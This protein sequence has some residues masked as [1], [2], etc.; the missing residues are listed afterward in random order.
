MAEKWKLSWSMP[1]G[2]P[3]LEILERTGQYVFHGSPAVIEVFE[4]R[5]ATQF[6]NKT[7]KNLPT[8]NRLFLH[9]ISHY[10]LYL[11]D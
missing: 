3:V 7:G 10:P 2:R 5:Q 4:P 9:L 6:D 8:E 11:K 1:E